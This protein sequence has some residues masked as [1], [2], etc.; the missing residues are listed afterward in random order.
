MQLIDNNTI[1]A[2]S[3]Y[4]GRKNQLSDEFRNFAESVRA[5]LGPWRETRRHEEGEKQLPNGLQVYARRYQFRKHANTTVGLSFWVDENAR[6]T[7]GLK[8]WVEFWTNQKDVIRIFA[9]HRLLTK[10]AANSKFNSPFKFWFESTEE[11]LWIGHSIPQRRWLVHDEKKAADGVR[12]VAA[13]LRRY[14]K[15]T[16]DLLGQ[17]A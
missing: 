16:E 3:T 5:Q 15:V 7:K 8:L 6:S 10:G 11:Y 4:L 1:T 17:F 2:L 9:K 14:L 13:L 12:D